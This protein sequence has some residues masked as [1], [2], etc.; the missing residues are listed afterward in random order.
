MNYIGNEFVGNYVINLQPCLTES[1]RMEP[2]QR[3]S[4]A[5]I[6]INIFEKGL[7]R[8]NLID[9][10]TNQLPNFLLITKNQAIRMKVM[11]A[12]NQKLFTEDLN[13]LETVNFVNFPDYF[14]YLH[15]GVNIVSAFA[16]LNLKFNST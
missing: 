13:T 7:N 14:P 11:K 10:I 6:F 16:I 2:V 12:F 8:G 5:D 15:C 4:A 9:V 3:R 1:T